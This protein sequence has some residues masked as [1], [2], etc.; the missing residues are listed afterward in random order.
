MYINEVAIKPNRANAM[1]PKVREH[2]STKTLKPTSYAIIDSYLNYGNRVWSRNI[3]TI[4][5]LNY[6]LEK[7]IENNEF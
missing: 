5:C 7:G 3:N 2:V 6:S 1:V 4:K